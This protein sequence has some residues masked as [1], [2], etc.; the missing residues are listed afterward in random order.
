VGGGVELAACAVRVTGHRGSESL[1]DGDIYSG[2]TLVVTRT[3]HVVAVS[4]TVFRVAT[5]RNLE[6][7]DVPGHTVGPVFRGKA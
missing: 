5:E 6:V 7:A 4:S 2:T 1:V 3:G